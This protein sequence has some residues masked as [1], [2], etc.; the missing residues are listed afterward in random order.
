MEADSDPKPD[1]KGNDLVHPEPFVLLKKA[2]PRSKKSCDLDKLNQPR[3]VF[4]RAERQA[5]E[6]NDS[7][8][9]SASKNVP[10]SVLCAAKSPVPLE[11]TLI[12]GSAATPDFNY[13][14]VIASIPNAIP[15]DQAAQCRVVELPDSTIET[16]PK[17]RRL[18]SITVNHLNFTSSS[19]PPP[20]VISS[21][22]TVKNLINASTS[23][24]NT[25]RRQEKDASL[26]S[27]AKR[28]SLSS[29]LLIYEKST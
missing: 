21:S 9:I 22:H 3:V 16:V 5:L 7:Y 14:Q 12:A 1:V 6:S 10:I 11:Q 28:V 13:S 19:S 8:L 25:R 24:A 18:A 20:V 29:I 17:R 2:F 15:S 23:A 26:L 27:P 4:R